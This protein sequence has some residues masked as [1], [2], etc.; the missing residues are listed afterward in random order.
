[1]LVLSCLVVDD[2]PKIRSLLS[3]AL[4]LEGWEVTAAASA[5]EAFTLFEEQGAEAFAVYLI[6]V[7]LPGDSGLDLVRHLREKELRNILLLTARDAVSDRVKG[8]EAG[9][10]DYIVKPFA[11]EELVARIKAVVRRDAQQ[12]PTESVGDCVWDSSSMQLTRRGELVELSPTE[13]KL[14]QVL[15]Y[16]RG[17][18][19]SRDMLLD[20]VWG[21]DFGGDDNVLDVYVGYLRKKLEA[22]GSPRLIS[23]VRGF[24]FCLKHES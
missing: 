12:S 2:D 10:D 17:K 3:R 13:R 18:A 23:T 9:A 21:Y 5:E 24:G 16:H 14:L 19:L 1:M 20:R 7:M 6:D 22:E 11:M 4:H 8:L 15:L